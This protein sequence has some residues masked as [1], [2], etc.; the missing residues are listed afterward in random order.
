MLSHPVP[1][2]LIQLGPLG[3][4]LDPSVSR[5][6][7]SHPFDCSSVALDGRL[8]TPPTSA[9]PPP[10]PRRKPFP[11][12]VTSAQTP[13]R[14][15]VARHERHQAYQYRRDLPGRVERLWVEVGYRKAEAG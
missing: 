11:L 3:P 5:F 9:V 4:K 1:I 15:L 14:H 7:C 13:R 6:D 10:A 12:R 8:H 2:L